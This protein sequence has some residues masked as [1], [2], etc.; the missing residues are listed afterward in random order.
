MGRDRTMLDDAAVLA[1]ACALATIAWTTL[2]ATLNRH[3][4][5][6]WCWGTLLP[7]GAA[8]VGRIHSVAA[9]GGPPRQLLVDLAAGA[10]A[11]CFTLAL[12]LAAAC[13][14]RRGGRLLRRQR[15]AVLRRLLQ[16][17]QPRQQTLR[18]LTCS[19]R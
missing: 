2:W 17:R 6:A 12:S 13:V 15:A 11:A 18:I 4:L 9:R 10:V 8:L 3:F 1:V 7:F 5:R 14:A 19:V 16:R